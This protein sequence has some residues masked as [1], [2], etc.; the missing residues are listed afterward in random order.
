MPD[1][2]TSRA[3]AGAVAAFGERVDGLRP[4]SQ[5]ERVKPRWRH[6]DDPELTPPVVEAY[7]ATYQMVIEDHATP[8]ALAAVLWC[9]ASR[10]TYVSDPGTDMLNF[11]AAQFNIAQQSIVWRSRCRIW[12]AR[13]SALGSLSTRLP[14]GLNAALITSA[15]ADR[16]SRVRF[17]AARCVSGC[18]ARSTLPALRRALQV[19]Q[20]DA[21][22]AFM[23]TMYHTCDKGWHV[24]ACA[25]DEDQVEL[26]LRTVRSGAGLSHTWHS[27]K[28][29]DRIGPEM[30]AT[31]AAKRPEPF[32]DGINPL[33]ATPSAAEPIWLHSVAHRPYVDPG[34]ANGASISKILKSR[35]GAAPART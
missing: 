5:D 33:P 3:F 13:R 26:C 21:T 35:H 28:L 20:D 4:V 9:A 23:N 1:A 12:Y 8:R 31:L 2:A 11:L 6:D 17:M 25:H 32:P 7:A 14:A 22:R 34:L 19:E 27:K 16:S 10:R 18:E 24:S 29:H 30:L 15:L